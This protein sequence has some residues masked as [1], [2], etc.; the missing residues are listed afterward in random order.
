MVMFGLTHTCTHRPFW[1]VR[2][3]RRGRKHVCFFLWLGYTAVCA[4][5]RPVDR[6]RAFGAPPLGDRVQLPL[7]CCA[8]KQTAPT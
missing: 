7:L 5:N 1:S 3:E 2:P 8:R 6:H 4:L